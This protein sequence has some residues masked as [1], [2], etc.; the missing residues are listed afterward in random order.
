MGEV[1]GTRSRLTPDFRRQLGLERYLLADKIK[2]FSLPNHYLIFEAITGLIVSI[3]LDSSCSRFSLSVVRLR[4]E[5]SARPRQARP[6]TDGR[7]VVQG[8]E[9]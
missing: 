9:L 2:A 1:K 8:P 7:G 6:E 4:E 3:S 5:R